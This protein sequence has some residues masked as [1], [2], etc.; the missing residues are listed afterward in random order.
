MNLNKI[1]Q[2]C[3]YQNKTEKITKEIMYA[4]IF[5]NDPFGNSKTSYLNSF[6]T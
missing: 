4:I 6:I 1:T 3:I 2:G 5:F